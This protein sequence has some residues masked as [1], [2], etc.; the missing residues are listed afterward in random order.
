MKVTG[1]FSNVLRRSAS[2]FIFISLMR[3]SSAIRGGGGDGGG[4]GGG[5]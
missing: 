3:K 1:H 4:G 5:I 2:L